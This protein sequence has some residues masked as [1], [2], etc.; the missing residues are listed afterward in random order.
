M[1]NSSPNNAPQKTA[2]GSPS[3]GPKTGKGIRNRAG[4]LIT[5]AKLM[6]V[7]S[8]TRNT[9][10]ASLLTLVISLGVT[11]YVFNDQRTDYIV[12]LKHDGTILPLQAMDQ[13]NL[14]SDAVVN[15]TQQV[16]C[17]IFTFNFNNIDARLLATRRY[18]T[19]GGWESFVNALYSEATGTSLYNAVRTQRQFRT[20]IA[21]QAPVVV[22][23]GDENGYYFWT[24]QMPIITS[25]YTGSTPA[26]TR[27][28]VTVK[29]QKIESHTSDSGYAFGITQ[30]TR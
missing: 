7:T 10:R 6:S 28:I 23:E 26:L 2:A 3:A 18:F 15:W 14:G 25:I 4:P 20:T 24:L 27:S 22:Q 12:A 1:S 21:A 30:I 13:P 5:Q 9:M 19:D 29:I 17:E 16:I 8:L 11:A